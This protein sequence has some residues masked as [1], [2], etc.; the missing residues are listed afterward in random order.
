MIIQTQTIQVLKIKGATP[1][2]VSYIWNKL[3]TGLT[4]TFKLFLYVEKKINV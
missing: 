1:Q 3:K 2:K 4:N